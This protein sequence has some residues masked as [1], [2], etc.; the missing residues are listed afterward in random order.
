MHGI[1][2]VQRRY[3]ALCSTGLHVLRL[4]ATLDCV[5]VSV[6]LVDSV[7]P[8]PFPRSSSPALFRHSSVMLSAYDVVSKGKV[9]PSQVKKC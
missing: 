9:T 2:T 1:Y 6:I 5:H 4:A 3:A 7:V 8:I